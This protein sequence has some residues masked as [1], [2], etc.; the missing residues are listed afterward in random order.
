MRF[1]IKSSG[2]D[3]DQN[4]FH[5]FTDRN[6]G[7]TRIKIT[8]SPSWPSFINTKLKLTSHTIN[9]TGDNDPVANFINSR[10]PIHRVKFRNH[11]TGEQLQDFYVDSDS[12]SGNR[13]IQNIGGKDGL[14]VDG[15]DDTITFTTPDSETLG[16]FYTM[17]F[18]WYPRETDSGWRTFYRGNNDHQPMIA[19]NSKSLGFYSNRV[20]NAFY[21][22]GY[23]IE[24]KW[25]TLIVVGRGTTALDGNG[26]SLYYVD[27]QYVGSVP[28]TKSGS[29]WSVFG[30]T[31]QYPG[32]FRDMGI[33]GSQI[34]SDEVSS[35]HTLLYESSLKRDQFT[36]NDY[37]SNIFHE[38]DDSE[39]PLSFD[40]DFTLSVSTT[41]LSN[42]K[43]NQF[44]NNTSKSRTRI[45]ITGE[46]RD[47]Y[48]PEGRQEL[49]SYNNLVPY[50]AA[51]VKNEDSFSRDITVRRQV[52]TNVSGGGGGGGGGS[53]TPDQIWY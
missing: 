33:F 10:D 26:E 41:L 51:A 43:G 5:Y 22:T 42:N 17:F 3:S 28:R 36:S 25:Q 20:G 45:F 1:T 50:D 24:L 34:D 4:H 53:S 40:S 6:G 2:H 16:Q 23:D 15:T 8:G 32:Y 39:S 12:L 14:D 35:L 18:V 21:D 13:S 29:T 27:G 31:G 37:T 38:A 49:I 46:R 30:W 19:D 9:G 47:Q 44:F 52:P 11:V 48:T 7:R